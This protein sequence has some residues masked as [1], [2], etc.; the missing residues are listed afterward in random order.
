MLLGSHFILTDFP[1]V[2]FSNAHHRLNVYSNTLSKQPEILAILM[3][4]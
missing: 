4:I 3:F 1:T 2:G